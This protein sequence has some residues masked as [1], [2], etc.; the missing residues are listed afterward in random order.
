MDSRSRSGK[1]EEDG[2][3]PENPGM[4]IEK[5]RNKSQQQQQ[6]HLGHKKNYRL[7]KDTLV[8][9]KIPPE[10]CSL[11]KI[12]EYFKKFGAIL[13]VSIDKNQLKAV[14]QYETIAGAQDAHSCPD[15]IFGNRFVKAYFLREFEENGLRSSNGL[16]SKDGSNAQPSVVS[17]DVEFAKPPQQV[18][19]EKGKQLI[20]LQR[21]QDAII[22]QQIE[23]SKVLMSQLLLPD[24]SPNEKK[25]I[26]EQL[27]VL[28]GSTQSLVEKASEHTRMLKLS[29]ASSQDDLERQRLDREL[30]VLNQMAA[31][32]DEATTDAEVDPELKSKLEA[33]KAEAR[34]LGIPGYSPSPRGRGRGGKYPRGGRCGRSLRLDNRSKKLLVTGVSENFQSALN[35]H[36]QVLILHLL[37]SRHLLVSRALLHKLA[38]QPLF[39]F[40]PV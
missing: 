10:S 24:I 12:H 31:V 33:L 29:T 3:D 37:I 21:N 1:M 30:E 11:E 15:S 14:I 35:E 19:Y 13:N 36:C 39:P 5:T 7:K 6:R 8:V 4:V 17:M 26:L 2:Y 22:A 34:A 38:D 18:F 28:Q 25:V 23:A 27:K 9:E 40:S 16:D 20:E 32:S